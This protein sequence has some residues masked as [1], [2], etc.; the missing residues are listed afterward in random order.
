MSIVTGAAVSNGSGRQT[1]TLEGQRHGNG[2]LDVDGDYS[3]TAWL[4]VLGPEP[5]VV[6]TTLARVLPSRGRAT[7]AVDEL[8]GM[9][10]LASVGLCRSLD[11]LARF[12]IALDLCDGHWSVRQTCPP[13]PEGLLADASPAARV[14]HRRAFPSEAGVLKLAGDVHPT[15][16][17]V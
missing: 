8:A 9:Y 12:G 11:R 14:A 5:W 15:V 13:L 17:R 7:W 1:L 3:R 4:P 16:H 10:G 6:W 2:L